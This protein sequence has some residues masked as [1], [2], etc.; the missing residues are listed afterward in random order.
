MKKPP[1]YTT[2]EIAEAY[3][4]SE[5]TVRLALRDQSLHGE[6]P[7]GSNRWLIQEQCAEAWSSGKKCPHYAENIRLM[8]EKTAPKAK[9]AS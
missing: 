6:K 5:Y 2:G 4:R 3:R 7:T 9:R 1:L 8:H